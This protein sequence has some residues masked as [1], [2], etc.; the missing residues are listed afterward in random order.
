MK[1]FFCVLPSHK[2]EKT[3]KMINFLELNLESVRNRMINNKILLCQDI[4]RFCCPL[5]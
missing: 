2:G 4:S 5:N 3:S 1:L